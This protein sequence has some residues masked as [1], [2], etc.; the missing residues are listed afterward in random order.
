[1]HGGPGGRDPQPGQDPGDAPRPPARPLTLEEVDEFA[2]QVGERIGGAASTHEAGVSP[3]HG[4]H[5]VHNGLRRQHEGPGRRPDGEPVPRAVP[6]DAK[7]LVGSVAGA[8]EMGEAPEPGSEEVVL[9]SEAV[10][11][12]LENVDQGGEG[13]AAGHAGTPEV[14]S[15]A[16]PA[17]DEQEWTEH[18][19]RVPGSPGG[20]LPEEQLQEFLPG[21]L[22]VGADVSQDGAQRAR[23]KGGVVGDR[24]VVFPAPEGGEADVAA[25][26]AIDGVP[27]R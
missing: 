14:V 1:M 22:R 23:A 17:G 4:A 7:P 15:Q 27:Q 13:T 12:L 10:D 16:D 21:Q 20:P 9:L 5:P 19:G 26:L 8:A 2:D 11:F 25:R 18:P 6:E 3:F 24:D